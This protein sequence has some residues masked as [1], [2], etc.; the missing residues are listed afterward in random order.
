[1]AVCP[2]VKAGTA[3]PDTEALVAADVR[4]VTTVLSRVATIVSCDDR[5]LVE[6]GSTMVEWPGA[7]P[8]SFDKQYLRN[9]LLA[10]GWNKT[11]PPPTLPPDVIAKT[12]ATYAEIQ[13][14]LLP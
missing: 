14:R 7:N 10:T 12:A 9:W 3:V 13:R 5:A 11:P 1:M 4:T 6:G 8:T 2:A